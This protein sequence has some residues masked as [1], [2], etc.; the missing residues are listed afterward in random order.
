MLTWKEAHH[1]ELWRIT[2][3]LQWW[4]Q[5]R[6]GLVSLHLALTCWKEKVATLVTH[7]HVST[8]ASFRNRAVPGD[9]LRAACTVGFT[10]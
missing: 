5:A 1:P 8:P 4:L 10:P 3:Y 2:V 6:C 9:A 7:G